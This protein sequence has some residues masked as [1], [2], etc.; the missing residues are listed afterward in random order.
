M[1]SRRALLH[2][3]SRDNSKLATEV[4]SVDVNYYIMSR[5]NS[6]VATRSLFS[7][8]ALTLKVTW[9]TVR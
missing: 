7:R 8:R 9:T 3:R 1:F 4:C 6:K 5:D 2:I